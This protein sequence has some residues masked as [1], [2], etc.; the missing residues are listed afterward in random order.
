MR[1]AA[2]IVALLTIVAGVAA[3]VAAT[4]AAAAGAQS[5]DTVVGV[6]AVDTRAGADKT[7]AF[8]RPSVVAQQTSLERSPQ[9]EISIRLRA[10]RSADW[11]IEMRYE[12]DTRNETAAFEEYAQEYEQGTT[13]VGPDEA[14]FGRVSQMAAEQAG[15]SMTVQNATTRG[16]VENGTG[17]LVLTF[18]WTNFLEQTDEGLR[19]GDALS[20]DD[21][22]TWL[23]SLRS[24]QN[25][26]IQTP[27]GHAVSDT[28]LPLENNAVVVEGPRTFESTDQLTVA[29][30]STGTDQGV[31]WALV[32]GGAVIL[33][34]AVAGVVLFTRRRPSGTEPAGTSVSPEPRQESV[35]EPTDEPAP[36][37]GDGEESDDDVDL[38]LLSDEERVELLLERSGGRMKQANIVKETGWSDA[39]VSQLLSAMADEERVEKLRLGRENLISLPDED[40]DD[41]AE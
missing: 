36:D 6:S 5:A 34:V 10:D 35:S 4:D 8:G 17:V 2:L 24:N 20:A 21:G 32:G 29:Y 16:Y 9:T 19:L 40:E 30:V 22:E 39:K 23:T 41:E 7:T 28:E 38:D 1:S 15:R 37:D 25:L 33:A 27:P 14:F 13:D 18:T 11:R 3:P 31:P 26:T 12:L